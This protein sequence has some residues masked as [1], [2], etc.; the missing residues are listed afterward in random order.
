MSRRADLQNHI[1]ASYDLIRQYE[2]ILR[3]SSD[4]REQARCR[5]AIAE[6]PIRALLGSGLYWRVLWKKLPRR[7]K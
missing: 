7:R 2:E 4:P 5:H 1:A 6:R 3:L